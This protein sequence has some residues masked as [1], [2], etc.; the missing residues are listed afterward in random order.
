MSVTMIR[1]YGLPSDAAGMYNG[2]GSYGANGP[3][4]AMPINV[5]SVALPHSPSLTRPAAGAY[6]A[7]LFHPLPDPEGSSYGGY[8]DFGFS[9][10]GSLQ[11]LGTR[12]LGGGL[13]GTDPGAG[14]PP[15]G[16]AGGGFDM[17]SLLPILGLGAVGIGLFLYFRKKR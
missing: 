9:L 8:G 10:T 11:N 1:G 14:A 6:Q 3:V 2:Y 4:R 7:A 17:G 13:P 12:V 16:G 15:A 5:P